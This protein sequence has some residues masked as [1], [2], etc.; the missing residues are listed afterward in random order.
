MMN[1]KEKLAAAL[2][3]AAAPAWMIVEAK[4]GR[5]DDF[6][7]E[8]ATPIMDLVRDCHAAG[9]NHIAERAKDGEFDA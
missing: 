1:A 4:C 7:S 3:E 8:S 6:E 9:L 5:Y 2:T